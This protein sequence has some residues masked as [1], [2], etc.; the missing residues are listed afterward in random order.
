MKNILGTNIVNKKVVSTKGKE[1]GEVKD[2]YFEDD[3]RIDSLVLI[4]HRA[5]TGVDEYL[6][7]RGL[8]IVSYENVKA[9]GEYVVMDFPPE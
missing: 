6:N 8:L 3:G 5:L 1:L 9:V 2:A 4:P 7:E